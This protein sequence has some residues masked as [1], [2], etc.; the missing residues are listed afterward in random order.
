MQHGQYKR[1]CWIVILITAE[2]KV[3]EWK[4]CMQSESPSR[5]EHFL[6]IHSNKSKGLFEEIYYKLL[7]LFTK[8]EFE[9]VNSIKEFPLISV[10]N[11]MKI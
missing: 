3:I 6:L 4:L 2:E 10:G 7:K 8:V 9:L 1:S 5:S 11:L